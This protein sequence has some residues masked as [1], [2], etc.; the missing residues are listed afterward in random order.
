MHQ[1]HGKYHKSLEIDFNVGKKSSQFSFLCSTHAS[2]K[3]S[4][5]VFYVHIIP[6]ALHV[7]RYSH[8]QSFYKSSW[9]RISH[10]ANDLDVREGKKKAHS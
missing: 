10:N 9:R 3:F 8:L 2:F 6:N 7:V 1:M 4:I 5:A